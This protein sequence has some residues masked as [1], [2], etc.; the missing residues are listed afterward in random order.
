[1]IAGEVVPFAVETPW[2]GQTYWAFSTSTDQGSIVA[3]TDIT[4]V[5]G[6]G[7]NIIQPTGPS[8]WVLHLN[9]AV[10]YTLGNTEANNIVIQLRLQPSATLQSPTITGISNAASYQPGLSP[11]ML[12]TVFGQNLSSVTGVASPGG[13]TSYQGVSITVGGRPAPLFSV[14]NINGAEQ[15]NFEVPSELSAPTVIVQL[16]NNGAVGSMSVTL[17]VVLPGIFQYVPGGSNIPYAA[18]VNPD[19]SVMGPS[20]PAVRGSTVAMF[21]T[22]LGAT[23]PFL[24][25]GQPGPVPPATTV[26]QP[27]IMGLNNGGVPALFSGIAPSFVGLNQVNFTIPADAPVGKAIG[28]SVTID[29]VS[30]HSSTIAI[31]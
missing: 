26:Y 19:G 11:G 22:G 15:I 14:V 29:G 17:T 18:I 20:N 28:F 30:S 10:H 16:N 4:N 9:D 5:L 7:E 12:A 1:V 21:M 3:F 27:I 2:A 25:T 6:L 23:T 8:T 31:Q 13:A 24:G